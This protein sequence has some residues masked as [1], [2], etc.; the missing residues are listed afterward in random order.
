MS[1]KNLDTHNRWRNKT[2]AFRVSPEENKQIDAAVRLSGLTK[3]DYITRRLLDRA[4]VV[5]GNP[6]VYKALRDQLAAVEQ[7]NSQTTTQSIAEETAENNPQE[8]DLEEMLRDMRRM[9][10]PAYL[11]TVSMNDLYQNI[12]QSRPPVIDG[13]L[14]PGTYLF[15]G[16]PKVGKSF[17][18]AQLAYHV[19]M[20]LPL[21]GYPVH[22]G[23]VL[24]LALEDDHRRLQG[25]LYRMFGTEGTDNLLFAVYAKQLGV[26]LE[27]Q[28]KKFVREHPNTKL[29]IIDTLQKIREA[30][31]DKYSYA[32]DY[33]V[34]GKLKRL[35]DD[36]GVCL[37]LVHHTRK[38][39]ADDKF[40]MI[41]GTNGLLGAADGAFLLQKEK[42]TDGSAVLDVA[43][44]DQQDQRFYLTRDKER[45]IWTLERTE[46]EAWT[47]PPDPVLEA[48]AALVT[49]EKPTWGG[50]ATELV[51]ALQTDMK[52]NAPGVTTVTAVTAFLRV[53]AV[54][55]TSSRSSRLSR[56]AAKFRRGAGCPF[57]RAALLGEATAVAGGK[58]PTPPRRAHDTLQTE[59]MKVS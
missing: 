25:R 19:S 50:T 58:A 7:P 44:R 32:N 38:Q 21:W 53:A 33:E 20:G 40:D 46:T 57:Q 51:A 29:I 48:I 8:K 6:R 4:V 11:H 15:A 28:L 47:E 9:N 52:P 54:S 14:Y 3:Q 10:D 16:A 42:R 2:V 43:G 22:K 45:L 37:L 41:S 34:V 30:G 35:A 56:G 12:Y 5:Q 17:L 26:G 55:E 18:M 49:A 36:C 39:Q 27:E 31:G 23:T 59:G 1:A 13:L 24:Y